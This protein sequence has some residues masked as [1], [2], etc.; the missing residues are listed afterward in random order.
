MTSPRLRE[1]LDAATPGEWRITGYNEPVAFCIRYGDSERGWD[2]THDEEWPEVD[3]HLLALAPELAALC[4]DMGDLLVRILDRDHH[5]DFING[6]NAA[7][8]DVGVLL[9]RLDRLG[10][11]SGD[12]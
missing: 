8:E 2:W 6:E 5:G 1:L 11:E 12:E 9:A 4:L 10:K 7:P 3:A